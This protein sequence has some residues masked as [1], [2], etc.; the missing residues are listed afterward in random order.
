[1]QRVAAELAG[2]EAAAAAI[3]VAAVLCEAADQPL[4]DVGPHAR[5]AAIAQSLTGGAKAQ[6]LRLAGI[7]IGDFFAHQRNQVG[8]QPGR[9]LELRQRQILDAVVDEDG[10]DGVVAG[11]AER[12]EVRQRL[13]QLISRKPA[14]ASQTRRSRCPRRVAH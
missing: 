12:L 8:L 11:D 14:R 1:M 6:G 2:R 10:D 3:L 4:D 9:L 13:A 7:G 5:M